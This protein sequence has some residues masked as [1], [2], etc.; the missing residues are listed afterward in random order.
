MEELS[1]PSPRS[2]PSPA[3]AA[4]RKG[5]ST[6]L[7]PL[8]LGSCCKAEALRQRPLVLRPSCARVQPRFSDPARCLRHRSC[9][10]TSRL[11]TDEAAALAWLVPAL[12]SFFP[13][14]GPALAAPGTA[15]AQQEL[16]LRWGPNGRGQLKSVSHRT[17][18]A[19]RD[20]AGASHSAACPRPPKE[21]DSPQLRSL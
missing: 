20:P 16:W 15:A 2:P 17:R 14:E 11:L 5:R 8:A 12:C 21:G 6:G 1:W 9:C 18:G 7:P 13:C 19:A 3:A 4:A 10:S